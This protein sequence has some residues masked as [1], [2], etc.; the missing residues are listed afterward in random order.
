VILLAELLEA[1][2]IATMQTSRVRKRNQERLNPA[3]IRTPESIFEG[4]L[5]RA[6][7]AKAF[8][9]YMM[10]AVLALLD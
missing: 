4:H 6:H 8:E 9:L 2:S 10:F 1:C 5:E 3:S 7:L